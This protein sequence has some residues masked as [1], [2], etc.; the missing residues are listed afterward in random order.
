MTKAEKLEIVRN[1][2]K[3]LK[4]QHKVIAEELKESEKALAPKDPQWCNFCQLLG[5]ATSIKS[6]LE[7][8]QNT[9]RA[10]ECLAKEYARKD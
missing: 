6:R 1:L 8:M 3:A 10:M 9:F 5:T 2:L 4:A 7:S